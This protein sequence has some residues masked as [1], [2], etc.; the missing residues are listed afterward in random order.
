MIWTYCVD[1]M[2][3]QTYQQHTHT[4]IHT[5]PTTLRYIY[6]CYNTSFLVAMVL[7]HSKISLCPLDVFIEQ[8]G[9]NTLGI[10]FRFGNTTR[11]IFTCR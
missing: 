10:T 8:T 7:V 9:Q 5:P 6:I 2:K 3:G 1:V 4:H 11:V